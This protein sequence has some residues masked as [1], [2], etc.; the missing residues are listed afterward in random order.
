MKLSDH[1]VCGGLK[2]EVGQYWF[3]QVEKETGGRVKIKAYW[4]GVLFNEEEQLNALSN[5]LDD[6]AAIYPDFYPKQLAIFGAYWLFPK[7]PEKWETIRWIYKTSIERIP[8]FA[9]ELDQAKIKILLMANGLPM[10][11]YGTLSYIFPQ[12]LRREKMEG[13]RQMESKTIRKSKSN[14]SSRYRGVVAIWHY[15]LGL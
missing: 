5:G 6:I 12:R 7:G 4:G 11:L 15:R 2:G 9:R 14:C 3:D 1:D 8:E 10:A 13:R